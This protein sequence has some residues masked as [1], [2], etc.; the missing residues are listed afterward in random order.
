MGGMFIPDAHVTQQNC[1]EAR[2]TRA[3]LTSS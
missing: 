3:L 1:G 2:L